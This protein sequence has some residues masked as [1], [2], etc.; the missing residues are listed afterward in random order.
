[1]QFSVTFMIF[2]TIGPLSKLTKIIMP[3]VAPIHPEDKQ[4]R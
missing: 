4:V 3:N 1:M 2:F